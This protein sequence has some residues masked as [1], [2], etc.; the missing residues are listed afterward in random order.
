MRVDHRRL[1]DH[2]QIDVERVL[3]VALEAALVRLVLE[4]AVDRHR[5]DAGRLAEPLRGAPGRRGERDLAV[6]EP[7]EVDDRLDD[8]R[9]ADAGAAGDH[10]ALVAQRGLDRAPLL[11]RRASTPV[12]ASNAWIAAWTSSASAARRRRDE[13]GELRRRTR[14]RRRAARGSAVHGP[15]CAEHLAHDQAGA[16]RARRAAAAAGR[17]RRRAARPRAAISSSS[18]RCMWPSS[19]LVSSAWSRPASSR[20]GASRAM[21]SFSAIASAVRN[22]MPQT[23]CASRY[24]LLRARR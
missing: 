22:P 12:T 4:Q 20:S 24:G 8:R 17:R 15:R 21:P 6:H 1:V 7:R 10:G 2:E 14:P 19:A 11:R 16:P 9:L 3:A 23:S 13:L 5:L 18:G